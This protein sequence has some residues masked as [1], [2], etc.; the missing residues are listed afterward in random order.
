MSAPARRRRLAA[1]AVA[2]FAALGLSALVATPA[3]AA[4]A[5]GFVRLAHLSPD[6]PNVDVYLNSLPGTPTV[7]QV[8]KG[9]GYGDVSQYLSLPVG[10]YTVA[11]RLSGAAPSTPAVL[12]TQVTVGT[13]G[14][15]T[16]AGVG[17]HADLGL[18]VLNDDLALP[19]AGKAKVRIVQASVSAP[20]LNVSQAG[21]DTVATGVQF[22]TTTDYRL[23]NPGRWTLSVQSVDGSR[24]ATLNANLAA[25]NVYS[26]LV[27]DGANGTLK[28]QLFTDASRTGTMPSGA[29]ATGAGGTA[30]RDTN[31]PVLVGG[32]LV[33]LVA[34]GL[35]VTRTRRLRR[36][37]R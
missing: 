15:Y 34:C 14:A 29:V 20:L 21:G 12:S 25:G 3:T 8:F 37:A 16:V 2:A 32:A 23:V 31:V 35:V 13:G 10:T 24:S 28:A 1:F 5:V 17:K 7:S 9:V 18:R 33:V 30:P 6:T 36:Q 4:G 26:L 27:L 22:A 11:M 19:G